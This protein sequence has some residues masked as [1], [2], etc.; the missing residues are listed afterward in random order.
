[1]RVSRMPPR[2]WR[3]RRSSLPSW[4][5]HSA[6]SRCRAGRLLSWTHTCG[7]GQGRPPGEERKTPN[8]QEMC[9]EDPDK[10]VT[11]EQK[12]LAASQGGANRYH[13]DEKEPPR[14]CDAGV[15]STG[16]RGRLRR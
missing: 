10:M 13:T 8:A 14:R 15:V 11:E 2:Y 7:R 6:R 4:R 9:P 5:R 1:M 12:G 16:L 3:I